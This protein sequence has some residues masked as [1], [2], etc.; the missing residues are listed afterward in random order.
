MM[1]SI[2]LFA[3][4]G[5]LATGLAEAGFTHDAVIEWDDVACETIRFNKQRGHPLVCDW[6]VIE[7]DVREMDYKSLGEIALVAGG[8]PCQPFSIGGKHKGREDN[9]DMLPVA[10]DIVRQTRPRAFV[11]EN[12]K[13]LTRAKY[14]TY[15]DYVLL[16]L[17]YP[18]IMRKDD[19]N[20]N[21]HLD[22]L[23]QHKTD[24]SIEGLSYNV[25]FRVLNAADYGV[26]QHRH[27]V[28]IVGFRN[29]VGADWHFPR[30]TH[31]EDALLYDQWVTGEYWERHEVP[32][33]D[34]PAIPKRKLRAIEKLKSGI[35]EFMG[36][37]WQ[38]VRDAIGDLPDPRECDIEYLNH[39]YN[40]GARIYPGHTG[41]PL[42]KPS[43]AL[44]AGVHGVPGGENMLRR[45]DGSVRY[46]TVREAARIQTFPDDYAFVGAWSRS[47][48]GLG[49]AVPVKLASIIGQSIAQR[50]AGDQLRR[51][52]A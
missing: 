11:F 23:E 5:G 7:G 46:F 50:L 42:D 27:R 12:V 29:D 15:L 3:G 41:S 9:R 45:V 44:K 32:R 13:G 33:G 8:P 37:P 1:N 39:E 47:M 6:R 43:K 19:E 40:D 24:G 48:R 10:V 21:E 18:E 31:T 14:E 22:R 49:N 51:T 26:P 30:P 2:E 28:F 25:I 16:R 38:T 52:A 34:R 17:S 20:V 4:V 35:A 36:K